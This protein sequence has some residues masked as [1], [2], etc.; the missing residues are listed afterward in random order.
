MDSIS[1]ELQSL[2]LEQIIAGPMQGVIKASAMAA[3]TT[4][5]FIESVGF[6]E[7][8]GTRR[9]NTASFMQNDTKINVPLLTLIPVPFI[10]IKTLKID[11]GFT[12]KTT[13]VE[14]T[15]VEKEGSFSLGIGFSIFSATVKGSYK[16]ST[17]N[18]TQNDEFAIL[19]VQVEAVQ[20]EIPSGLKKLLSIFED[21]IKAESKQS[22]TPIPQVTA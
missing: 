12:I 1:N 22:T 4:L 11:F 19:K 16:S 9:I 14:K 20:D 2:P 6:T 10:R 18:S 21:S 3:Q 5:D 8:N 7:E 15:S 13:E 17:E